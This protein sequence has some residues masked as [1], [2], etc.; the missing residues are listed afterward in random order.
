MKAFVVVLATNGVKF[1]VWNTPVEV[2]SRQL[3]NLNQ[4]LSDL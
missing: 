2:S 3:K 1:Q 4:F